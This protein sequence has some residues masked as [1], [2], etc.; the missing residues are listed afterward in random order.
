[1]RGSSEALQQL[2]E[3]GNLLVISHADVRKQEQRRC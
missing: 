2:V 1:L 3:V